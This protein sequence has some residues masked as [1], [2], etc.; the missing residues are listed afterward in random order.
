MST[1]H[2]AKGLEREYV[3]VR[4]LTNWTFPSW[5]CGKC[6]NYK[7]VPNECRLNLNKVFSDKVFLKEYL[8]EGLCSIGRTKT[9]SGCVETDKSNIK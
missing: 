6:K 8:E 1:I 4:G 7:D 3:L 2:G 5:L 9:K